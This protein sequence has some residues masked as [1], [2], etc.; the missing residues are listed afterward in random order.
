LIC[1]HAGVLQRAAQ[2]AL[3]SRSFFIAVL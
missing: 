3:N 1:D 2:A